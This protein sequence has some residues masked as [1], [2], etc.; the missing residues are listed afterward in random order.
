MCVLD[1]TADNS[2]C[3]YIHCIHDGSLSLDGRLPYHSMF[4]GLGRHP[5]CRGS[6]ACQRTIP[7]AERQAQAHKAEQVRMATAR[8]P[9]Q[10]PQQK[11][12]Q[13]CCTL[14][15]GTYMAHTCLDHLEQD[16]RYKA[17]KSYA[18]FPCGRPLRVLNR[19]ALHSQSNGHYISCMHHL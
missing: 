18:Q 8:L 5:C 6:A 7:T 3:M 9:E 13:S 14:F 10:E 19:L 16:L 12:L 2:S 15:T 4:A 1:M 17:C 11:A